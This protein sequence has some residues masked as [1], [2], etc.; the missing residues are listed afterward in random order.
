[1][2]YYVIS[3]CV[4]IDCS[5]INN[6]FFFR[7]MSD[8]IPIICYFDGKLTIKEN[9]TP[10]Y[11]GGK[12]K[13]SKVKFF[14]SYHELKETVYRVT[15]INSQEYDVKLVSKWVT[16]SGSSAIDV[17]DDE[18]VDALFSVTMKVIELFVIKEEL[19]HFEDANTTNLNQHSTQILGTIPSYPYQSNPSPVFPT[20]VNTK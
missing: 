16:D 19:R 20:C 7:S 10:V 12:Q 18:D 9:N 17:N 15:K 5:K 1:M 8:F 14:C 13:G 3:I 2:L 6:V 4:V 11:V